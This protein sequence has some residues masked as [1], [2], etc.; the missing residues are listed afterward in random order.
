MVTSKKETTRT[1]GSP[2][3]R[4]ER[5]V[6]GEGGPVFLPPRKLSPQAQALLSSPPEGDRVTAYDD[7]WYLGRPSA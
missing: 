1:N 4:R 7:I 5:S 6:Y 2:V 3:V